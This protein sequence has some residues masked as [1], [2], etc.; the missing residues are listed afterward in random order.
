MA[1]GYASLLM[2]LLKLNVMQWLMEIFY[3]VGKLALTNYF[4]QV[5]IAAFWFYGYGLGFYGR[6]EQWEL[7]AAV[8]EITLVQIVFSV[9]WLRYYKMGPLEWTLKSLIYRKR[10]SNKL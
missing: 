7:Y 1:T 3:S 10:F 2:W 4:L 9:L 6:Y 5:F 8:A